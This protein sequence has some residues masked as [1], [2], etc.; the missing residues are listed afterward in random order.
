MFSILGDLLD[1]K[2]FKAGLGLAVVIIPEEVLA[3]FV[4]A[5][6]GL[7]GGLC[8]AR[9][10]SIPHPAAAAL[11]AGGP[12]GPGRPAVRDALFDKA[13]LGLEGRASTGS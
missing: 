13:F 3:A 6:L 10:C 7:V 4:V 2:W 1:R 5:N 12:G 9:S 8:V 11:G